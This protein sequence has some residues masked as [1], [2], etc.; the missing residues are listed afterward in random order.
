MNLGQ[1]MPCRDRFPL[2]RRTYFGFGDKLREAGA[3]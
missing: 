1:P 2:A 3:R